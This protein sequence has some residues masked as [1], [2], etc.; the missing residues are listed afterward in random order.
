MGVRLRL[1]GVAFATFALV[2]ACGS[3]G[4]GENKVASISDPAKPSNQQ[5]AGDDKAGDEQKM[6]DFTKCM[7]EH[8]IDMPEPKTGPGGGAMIELHGEPGDE[9]KMKAADEACKPLLPN[10]GVPPKL[11][12]AQLDKLREQAKCMREHGVNMPDPDPNNPGIRIEG[13]GD[14]EKDKAAFEACMGKDGGISI[15]GKDSGGDSGPGLS[16]GGGK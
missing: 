11:D 14:P 12:A 6:R 2:T 10:G 13:T 9:E 16:T 15:D 8:G 1:A 7:R 4:G 5:Q 3:G